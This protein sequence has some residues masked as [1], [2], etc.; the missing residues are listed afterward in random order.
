MMME[1][2][3]A[4]PWHAASP[5]ILMITSWRLC[6][7]ATPRLMMSQVAPSPSMATASSAFAFWSPSVRILSWMTMEE[8]FAKVDRVT[9]S[10]SSIPPICEVSI[11]MEAPSPSSTTVV[12]F[13]RRLPRPVPSP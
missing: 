4:C 9:R 10:V 2:H 6:S 11:S 5:S 13:I 7:F 8:R 1:S 12:G 3:S